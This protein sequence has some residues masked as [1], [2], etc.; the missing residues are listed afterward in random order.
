M[1]LQNT[2]F[3]IHR[4]KNRSDEAQ[5]ST[6]T[7]LKKQYIQELS[8]ENKNINKPVLARIVCY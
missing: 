5:N 6:E 4:N 8:M 3:K 7:F 1:S 2:S